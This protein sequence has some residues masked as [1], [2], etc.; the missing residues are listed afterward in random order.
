MQLIEQ[1]AEEE[2]A[3]P[4]GRSSS[5]LLVTLTPAAN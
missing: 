1:G 3:V 4:Y 5:A 2:E